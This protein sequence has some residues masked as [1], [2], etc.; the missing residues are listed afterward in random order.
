MLVSSFPTFVFLMT[1]PLTADVPEI[2]SNSAKSGAS[3]HGHRG[4]AKCRHAL[5]EQQQGG[6]DRVVVL[7]VGDRFKFAL[8]NLALVKVQFS[9]NEI[10]STPAT[11]FKWS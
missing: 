2:G 8:W 3:G 5:A 4:R 1:F 7:H 6:Q 9:S 11:V 10:F